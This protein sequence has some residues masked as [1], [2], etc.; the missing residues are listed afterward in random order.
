M[1]SR[2]EV[3]EILRGAK[4]E[5]VQEFDVRAI[6]VFGSVARGEARE[7]SDVDIVV[8]LARPN[9]FRMVHLKARLEGLLGE[10]VDLLRYR[11]SLGARLKS[12]IAREAVYV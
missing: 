12:R 3:L 4:P 9:L 2:E 10:A 5:L 6:G 7:D 11:D 8:E 1:K